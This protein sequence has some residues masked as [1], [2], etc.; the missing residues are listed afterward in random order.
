LNLLGRSASIRRSW[1]DLFYDRRGPSDAEIL[2]HL[3]VRPYVA[4]GGWPSLC[5]PDITHRNRRHAEE[6]YT[7]RKL[8]TWSTQRGWPIPLPCKGRRVFSDEV[9]AR[10]PLWLGRQV[11]QKQRSLCKTGKAMPFDRLRTY[12]THDWFGSA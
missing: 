11:E 6:Y 4:E 2:V 5:P 8:S 10:S 1:R 7:K 9:S 12:G 3:S